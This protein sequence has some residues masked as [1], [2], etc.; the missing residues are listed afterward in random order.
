MIKIY[1][2]NR[3]I[4]LSL[5]EKTGQK[6]GIHAVNISEI[7]DI[8]VKINRFINNNKIKHLNIYG[9]DPK[10]SLEFVKN[11]YKLILA[12][13][14]LVKNENSLYLFIY[15]RKKWDLPKGKAEK[16]EIPKTCAVR[17]VSEECN[18]DQQKL[19]VK[20]KLGITYHMYKHKGT[21][22]LKENHWFNMIYKGEND[23][24]RP[25]LEEDI[26]L[27]RWV[28]ETE[29]PELMQNTFPSIYDIIKKQILYNKEM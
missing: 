5:D 28:D 17:E 24:I 12:G 22:V 7:S 16:N 8:K 6:A 15:R 1:Y 25:Q 3:L 18:V 19:E 29:I 26:E 23:T 2:K 13:G 20:Q 27:C 4:S 14:G 9:T 10:R 11:A 21:T